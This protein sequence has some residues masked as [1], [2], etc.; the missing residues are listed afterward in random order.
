MPTRGTYTQRLARTQAIASASWRILKEDKALLLLPIA[1]SICLLL[2]VGAYLEPLVRE[3][4]AAGSGVEGIR[5]IESASEIGA[6]LITVATVA[7]GIY[8]NAALAF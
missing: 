1:S 8:F 2:I 5:N 3:I 6:Y 7:V 4:I